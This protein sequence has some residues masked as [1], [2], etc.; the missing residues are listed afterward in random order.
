MLSEPD[1]PVEI[2]GYIDG[3]V[4]DVIEKEGV[5]LEAIGSLIQG[6]IGIGEKL[7]HPKPRLKIL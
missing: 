4:V 7:A 6:I 3:K 2:N 1:I 5:V